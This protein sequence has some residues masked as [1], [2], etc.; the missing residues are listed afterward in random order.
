[1]DGLVKLM[2]MMLMLRQR[3]GIFP[4]LGEK[5]KLKWYLYYRISSTL[6]LNV[7]NFEAA[8]LRR[9]PIIH[10]AASNHVDLAISGSFVVNET[11]PECQA[12]L[13]TVDSTE[14]RR[15]GSAWREILLPK[16]HRSL[17]VDGNTHI[18][19]QDGAYV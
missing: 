8:N 6:T 9:L 4:G 18:C 1:M 12:W 15:T 17:Y 19:Y 2:R 13:D 14:W 11:L 5:T 10:T 16:A 7:A 3:R